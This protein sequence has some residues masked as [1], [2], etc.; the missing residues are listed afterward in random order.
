MFLH[1][2]FFICLIR[3]SVFFLRKKIEKEKA[4]RNGKNFSFCF[5]MRLSYQKKTKGFR[6]KFTIHGVCR[7]RSM[8]IFHFSLNI[9]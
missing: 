5:T 1:H 4:L 8:L 9:V 3:R 2:E 7:T 6:D